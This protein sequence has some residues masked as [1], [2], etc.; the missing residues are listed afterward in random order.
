MAMRS[1]HP[2]VG[3][4]LIDPEPFHGADPSG[5]AILRNPKVS[6]SAYEAWD[7]LH[8]GPSANSRNISVV[9]TELAS[10]PRDSILDAWS[11]EMLLTGGALH[12]LVVGRQGRPVGRS[13]V[14]GQVV[15]YP[16]DGRSSR[17]SRPR[18][19]DEAHSRPTRPRRQA[20]PCRS[21]RASRRPGA[22]PRGRRPSSSAYASRARRRGLPGRACRRGRT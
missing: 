20:T 8:I 19:A 9:R 11:D 4:P 16:G 7:F 18:S 6:A 10:C 22:R 17:R 21:P 5:G 14:V 13:T 2:G 12:R 3:D 15:K 1:A